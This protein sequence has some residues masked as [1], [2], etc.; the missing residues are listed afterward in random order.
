MLYDT[1]KN[2]SGKGSYVIYL[3]LSNYFYLLLHIFG[4]SYSQWFQSVLFP[5]YQGQL[6]KYIKIE[7]SAKLHLQLYNTYEIG[8]RPFPGG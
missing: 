5:Q 2:F 8:L 6:S 1:C 3:L 4:K 7:I